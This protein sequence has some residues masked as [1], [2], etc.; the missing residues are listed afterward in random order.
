MIA[1]KF[2]GGL[3][4]DDCA[5]ERIV[6]LE[7]QEVEDTGDDLTYP[8]GPLEDGGGE[9]D[10]PEVCV[11][12]GE[13]LANPLTEA[14]REYV[15]ESLRS[16]PTID[17]ISH[18]GEYYAVQAYDQ[19]PK[20]IGSVH[21]QI[22]YRTLR[23]WRRFIPDVMALHE[24]QT[25]WTL[26]GWVVFNTGD[27]ETAPMSA[28]AS[29]VHGTQVGAWNWLADVDLEATKPLSLKVTAREPVVAGAA[30]DDDER[31]ACDQCGTEFDIE[32]DA[33]ACCDGEDD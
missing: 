27:Q 28:R 12:C 16:N 31:Y 23:G 18:W 13:F 25:D 7:T 21:G 11:T 8:Q 20:L 10:K 3:Y 30:N 4:C 24:G 17:S 32:E 26:S 29:V 9:S 14:G 6:E 5:N 1:W 33:W 15:R 2:N 19:P 22:L